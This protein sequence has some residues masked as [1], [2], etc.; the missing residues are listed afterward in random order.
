[1]IIAIGIFIAANVAVIIQNTRKTDFMQML[2]NV[3]SIKIETVSNFLIIYTIAG[4]N[5]RSR[6]ENVTMMA[7][8]LTE[9]L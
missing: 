9:P 5:S 3:I 6:A 2:L 1:M 8:F 4:L 7:L